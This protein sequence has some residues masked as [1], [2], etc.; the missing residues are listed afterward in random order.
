MTTPQNRKT[1]LIIE[2]DEL[3]LT[4]LQDELVNAG[5]SVII[6][7]TGEDGLLQIKQANPKVDLIFLDLMLPKMS[8]FD[9]L[10]QLKY[11]ERFRNVP[12]IVLSNLGE[13]R[14][15]KSA[16]ELGASDYFIKADMTPEKIL[17]ATDKIRA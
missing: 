12:V 11:D 4:L 1:I 8:G 17:E 13:E 14:D 10:K 15:I 3:L 16:L 9:V 7:K 2:D 6:S 5:H